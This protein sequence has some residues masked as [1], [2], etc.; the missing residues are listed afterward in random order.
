MGITESVSLT[1]IGVHQP[2]R[3]EVSEAKRLS[4]N[5][6]L[7]ERRFETLQVLGTWDA[8]AVVAPIDDLQR[9]SS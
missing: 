1:K 7:L 5:K 9:S 2:S 4:L 3:E 8:S 6:W